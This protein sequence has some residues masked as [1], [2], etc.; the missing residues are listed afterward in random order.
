MEI[1]AIAEFILETDM[2]NFSPGFNI[3]PGA[4]IEIAREES[5]ENQERF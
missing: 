2:E 3:S 4:K 1:Y 5:S